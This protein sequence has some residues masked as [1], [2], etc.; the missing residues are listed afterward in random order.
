MGNTLQDTVD[1]IK[2]FCR[3][4]S[5]NIGSSGQP[6]IGIASTVRNIILSAP[7]VWNFNRNN[8]DL[9][10]NDTPVPLG[11]RKGVQ[12]YIQNIPDFGFLEKA[13]AN[14][15]DGNGGTT[16]WEFSDM[17]NN[18][19]LGSSTTEARPKSISAFYD[20][21]NFNM[22]FRLSAVP[23]QVYVINM[24]YQKEP[25]KFTQSTDFWA[26]IPDSFSDVYNNIC[27]GYYMDSCQDPRAPQYIARGIAGLLAR[28]DGLSSTDKAIFA[29]AYMNFQSA[30][31]LNQ[32]R[33]QQGTQALGSR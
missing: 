15:P 24:V 16:S 18:E 1:L 11:V 19:P 3:Y 14:C 21:G 29:S 32:A 6:I 13:T 4:Q 9:V 8:V 33:T 22:T 12:D 5:A 23:D 2:P 31:M 17:K 27:L 7:F 28:A 30:E 25:I 10:G 20:D 26:P